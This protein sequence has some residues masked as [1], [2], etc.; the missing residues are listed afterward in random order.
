MCCL[1][2]LA[3]LL[4]FGCWLRN[5]VT[6]H[7]RI[8]CKVWVSSNSYMEQFYVC[9]TIMIFIDLRHFVFIWNILV[10]LI[11]SWDPRKPGLYLSVVCHYLILSLPLTLP[12]TP[13]HWNRQVCWL[14][15]FYFF[16]RG[17]FLG[18]NRR[19]E[20]NEGQSQQSLTQAYLCFT[21]V[22][23]HCPP[24]LCLNFRQILD[25]VLS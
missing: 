17:H 23:L 11:N 22:P 4:I 21:S 19:E 25:T 24:Q 12:I 13:K 8:L 10:L 3:S 6:T 20:Y 1:Y 9:T 18:I 15:C 16:H 14:V 2:L 7:I 5:L